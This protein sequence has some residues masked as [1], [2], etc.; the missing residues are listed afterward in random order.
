MSIDPQRAA[1]DLIEPHQQVDQGRLAAAGGA[2]KGDALAGCDLQIHVLNQGN[3][4][5]V[6]ELD[7]VELDAARTV[8]QCHRVRGI[9]RDGCLIDEVKHALCAGKGV[10]QFGHN[11]GDIVEGLRVL[12]RVVQKHRQLT[13]RD[14]ARNGDECAQHADGGVDQRIDKSGA[15]VRGGGEERRFDATLLQIEVDLVKA[16]LGAAFV[17]EGTNHMLIANQLFHQAGHL[18]AGLALHLEHRI[19]MG[20]NEPRHKDGQWRQRHDHQRNAPVNENHHAQ[21]AKNRQHAGKQLGKTHQQTVAE[22][23]YIGG[24][25]ADSVAGAVGVHIFQR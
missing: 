3:I 4:V 19:G 14:A 10:L 21:R 17:A 20:G 16:F 7:V 9:W 22:L 6:A 11:V 8:G 5:H 15:G 24:D 18:G 23:L 1:V 13:D 2:D 25:A 12:V